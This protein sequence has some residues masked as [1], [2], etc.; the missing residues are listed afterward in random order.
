MDTKSNIIT[1][2]TE[3]LLG[4]SPNENQRTRLLL[5]V[6]A[7]SGK[8]YSQWHSHW[9]SRG[10]LDSQNFAKKREK[11]S[12]KWVKKGKNWEKEDKSGRFFHF[13]PPDV[14]DRAGYATAY[15]TGKMVNTSISNI[16][17]MN[18]EGLLVVGLTQMFWWKSR[19]VAI[20]LL[21]LILLHVL[22]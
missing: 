6:L 17:T 18:T 12:K 10:Q 7:I 2:D 5:K 16:I 19:I 9:G 8:T 3:G 22:I 14:T 1:I 4:V 13:A 15:G 20:F 21:F 11:F